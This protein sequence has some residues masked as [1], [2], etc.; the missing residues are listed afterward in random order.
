MAHEI[1]A[2]TTLF[3][4]QL[5]QFDQVDVTPLVPVMVH[6]YQH[7]VE[8]L[9]WLQLWIIMCKVDHAPSAIAAE[10]VFREH[11][12]PTTERLNAFQSA[13]A[14]DVL[15]NSIKPE[16]ASVA[17]ALGNLRIMLLRF[18]RTRPFSDI[19][20]DSAY[21]M[22]LSGHHRL[23]KTIEGKRGVWGPVK[24]A[25]AD[26]ES[27]S[28]VVGGATDGQEGVIESQCPRS[29]PFQEA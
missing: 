17:T 25:S 14:F 16:L 6:T 19:G 3:E 13:G 18:Y 9:W 5:E 24:I 7:D 4:Q 12:A 26:E 23:F 8:S 29:P 20:K 2:G 28:K 10:P 11:G 1:L 15:R 21:G 22:I 27:R